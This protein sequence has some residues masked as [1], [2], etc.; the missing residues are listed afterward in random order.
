[1]A[2]RSEEEEELPADYDIEKDPEC[3]VVCVR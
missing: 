1:M 2:K 3:I